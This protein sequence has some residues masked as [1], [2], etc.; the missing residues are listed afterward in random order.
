MRVFQNFADKSFAE[1]TSF[2]EGVIE[3]HTNQN[4]ITQLNLISII[5]AV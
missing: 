3:I 1:K 2:R 5:I 4:G